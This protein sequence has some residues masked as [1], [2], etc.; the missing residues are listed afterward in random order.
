[1]SA[2]PGS[3][4]LCRSPVVWVT[5]DV[6]HGGDRRPR[7]LAVGRCSPP[8]PASPGCGPP[9]CPLCQGRI[10]GPPEGSGRGRNSGAAAVLR[11]WLVGAAGSDFL[12]PLEKCRRGPRYISRPKLCVLI[13][14]L[15]WVQ[16]HLLF[17]IVVS[18]AVPTLSLSLYLSGVQ[19]K[20]IPVLQLLCIV[21]SISI[22]KIQTALY[23][24]ALFL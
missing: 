2:A 7:R 24:F 12:F 3:G 15:S 1:M 21:K 9:I 23:R 17:G 14:H 4:A 20:N 22:R 11:R 19:D 6:L 8:A 16:D 18:R 5:G 13:L 10:R